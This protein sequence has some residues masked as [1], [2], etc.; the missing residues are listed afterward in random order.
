VI[1]GIAIIQKNKIYQQNG[2]CVFRIDHEIWINDKQK[3]INQFIEIV[4][5]LKERRK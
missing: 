2:F 5:I 1:V 3:I 4:D